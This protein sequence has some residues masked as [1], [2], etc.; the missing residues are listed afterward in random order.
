MVIKTGLDNFIFCLLY[1]FLFTI[2]FS[3][4]PGHGF[5]DRPAM[6]VPQLL[7]KILPG[8]YRWVKH[9]IAGF[10][11]LIPTGFTH[12]AVQQYLIYLA[13]LLMRS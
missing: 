2:P 8:F 13:I 12:I 1:G 5:D 10:G 9:Q 3:A 4:N 11:K 7:M 6:L